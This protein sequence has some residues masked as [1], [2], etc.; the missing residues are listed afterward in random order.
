MLPSYTDIRSVVFSEHI[1]ISGRTLRLPFPVILKLVEVPGSWG[2]GQDFRRSLSCLLP[3]A[4]AVLLRSVSYVVGLPWK[5]L[6]VVV[7][8]FLQTIDQ[9]NFQRRKP[10]LH[11]S[12]GW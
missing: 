8:D 7:E 3:S 2:N 12:C 10:R 5:S 9:V 11:N 1:F 6:L 4:R